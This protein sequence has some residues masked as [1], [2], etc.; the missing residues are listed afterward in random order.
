M[1]KRRGENTRA[2]SNSKQLSPIHVLGEIHDRTG[3]ENG[4][5]LVELSKVSARSVSKY[6]VHAPKYETKRNFR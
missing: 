5:C 2:T 6:A 3:V 1:R 4:K